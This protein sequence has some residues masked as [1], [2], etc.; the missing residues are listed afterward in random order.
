MTLAKYALASILG[1]AIVTAP[2]FAQPAPD[3]LKKSVDKAVERLE[4]VTKDLQEARDAL[5]NDDLRGKVITI[6]TKLDMLDKDIQ[7]IKKDVRELRRRAG[8]GTATTL[9][10]D[11]DSTTVRGR[12]QVRFINEFSEEMSVVVNDR[13][14]RLRPGE[15]RLVPVPPGDF[16]YQ[17]LQLQR[18]PQ[19][20]RIAADET[21]TVRIYPI[22]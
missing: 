22:P 1:A 5:K 7:D 13:S 14:F 10:P 15:E 20:R 21:K 8:E 4:K 2:T 19:V 18:L 12:G 6:D 11:Y 9:R 17:V 3:D 16:T